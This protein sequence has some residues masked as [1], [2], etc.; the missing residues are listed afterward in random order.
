MIK[1]C[2]RG[3]TAALVASRLLWRRRGGNAAAFVLTPDEETDPK[4]TSEGAKKM[5]NL[6]P[7]EVGGEGEGLSTSLAF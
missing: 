2:R 3:E 4:F 6:A 1:V 5:F 7:V